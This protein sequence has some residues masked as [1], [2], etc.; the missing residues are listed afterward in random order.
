V[1]LAPAYAFDT[2]LPGWLVL[3]PTRHVSALRELAPQETL[4][5]GDL[6]VKLSAALH[7]VL[8]CEKTYVALFAETEGFAH[9]HYHVAAHGLVQSTATWAPSV[10]SM[11][12]YCLGAWVGCA[13]I[14]RRVLTV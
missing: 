5:M 10:L 3:A 13:D 1:R 14:G 8:G 11:D 7:T 2:G 9:L 4:A 6:L 12:I